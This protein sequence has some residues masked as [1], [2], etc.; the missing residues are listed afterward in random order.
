M[1]DILHNLKIINDRIKKACEKAGRNPGKV[2]LL[3]ATKTVSAEHIR[4]A[5]ENGQTLIAENKV[6]E[7][8]EKY[9]E[10]KKYPRKIIYDLIN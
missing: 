2:M 5:L 1:K 7:L 6:Q 9:D 3:P 8:K 10:L 4:T